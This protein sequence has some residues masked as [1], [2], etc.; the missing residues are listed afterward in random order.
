MGK[1]SSLSRLHLVP[2]AIPA[3]GGGE[4]PPGEPGKACSSSIE[5]PAPAEEAPLRPPRLRVFAGFRV[6]PGPAPSRAASAPAS[7]PPPTRVRLGLRPL[8][9]PPACAPGPVACP[10]FVSSQLGSWA[11]SGVRYLCCE[12]GTVWGSLSEPRPVSAGLPGKVQV[13]GAG[14]PAGSWGPAFAGPISSASSSRG[15]ASRSSLPCSGRLPGPTVGI[16]RTSDQ[17]W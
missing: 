4:A 2:P 17:R 7:A 13:G 15:G 12:L 10:A 8:A 14:S 16:C 5:G 11:P 1:R 6:R 9:L 3:L